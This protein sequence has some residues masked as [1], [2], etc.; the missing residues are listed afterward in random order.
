MRL[1]ISLPLSL[2]FL[3][4]YF[5]N[6]NLIITKSTQIIKN[7]VDSEFCLLYDLRTS[8]KAKSKRQRVLTHFTLGT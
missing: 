6:L 1:L 4:H 2:S 5:S 8:R 7:V 3:S